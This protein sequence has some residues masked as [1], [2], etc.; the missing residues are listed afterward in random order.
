VIVSAGA[1]GVPFWNYR[2]RCR[3]RCRVQVQVE[4]QSAGA[5]QVHG[6]QEYGRCR[7]QS[8]DWVHVQIRNALGA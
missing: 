5:M 6:M 7:M 8:A 3:C 1:D 4:V 2:C